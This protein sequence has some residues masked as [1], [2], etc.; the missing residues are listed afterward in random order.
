MTECAEKEL[1]RKPVGPAR[2]LG[3]HGQLGL[4]K[5][6]VL[7]ESRNSLPP[8]TVETSPFNCFKSCRELKIEA[9]WREERVLW[10]HFVCFGFY[11]PPW[12]A[13]KTWRSQ[14]SKKALQRNE[15]PSRQNEGKFPTSTGTLS[16]GDWKRV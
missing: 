9:F 11:L 13:A 8:Q 5:V 7:R 2:A 16:G 10:G 15:T 4:S 12:N 3:S 14:H 6:G 1:P